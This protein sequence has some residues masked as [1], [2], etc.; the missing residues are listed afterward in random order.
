MMI[1]LISG[2]TWQIPGALPFVCFWNEGGSFGCPELRAS[3]GLGHSCQNKHEEG[4]DSQYGPCGWVGRWRLEPQQPQNSL[5]RFLTGVWNCK[6][7]ELVVFVWYNYFLQ[8]FHLYI[9]FSTT[10]YHKLKSGK[11]EISKNTINFCNSWK[12]QASGIQ[13]M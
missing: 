3:E 8:I 13:F 2:A 6:T 5:P 1:I 4:W 10:K 7:S 9:Y 12:S 11:S